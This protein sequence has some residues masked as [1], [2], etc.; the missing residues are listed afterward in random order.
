MER[1][2]S[3]SLASLVKW[4]CYLDFNKAIEGGANNM[5][6]KFSK[7][8][9]LI[10]FVVGLVCG[11]GSR[12]I[13]AMPQHGGHSGN[14]TQ[15][16]ED[17][18]IKYLQRL[19][20]TTVNMLIATR[21]V[22]TKN[23]ELINRDPT[24]G[25]YYFKGFVPAIVG[26]EVA[27]D[28]SLMTCY[29]LKQ[30]SLNIRNPSNAPDE[31]ERN[32][33]ELFNSNKLQKDKGI[34]EIQDTGNK[35]VYRYLKPLYVTKPCLECHGAKEGIRPEISEFLEKRYPDDN[36]LGYKEGDLRG[37]IS[38]MIPLEDFDLE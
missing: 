20:E 35:K 8:T 5:F 17:K 31:W 16:I 30:T 28:F 15:N 26:S 24:T 7:I 18:Q 23:Q 29:K 25:N 10:I 36:A 13:F 3:V 38:M 19:A 4:P 2:D 11:F 1:V 32:K 34:G 6:S 27:N 12:S 33:L 37:G 14:I 9:F 21:S 22:I